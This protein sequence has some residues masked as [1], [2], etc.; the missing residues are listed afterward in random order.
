M[1]TSIPDTAVITQAIIPIATVRDVESSGP[2]TPRMD[3]N[4][5]PDIEHVYVN[6]DPRKWSPKSKVSSFRFMSRLAVPPCAYLSADC[7]SSLYIGEYIVH[8]L[9]CHDG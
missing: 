3:A 2:P 9:L 5:V 7:S 8:G 1:A 6:D 4:W